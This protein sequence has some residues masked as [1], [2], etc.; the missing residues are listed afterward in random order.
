MADPKD[1]IYE[2]DPHTRAK[3]AILREYMKRWL[4][5]LSRQAKNVGSGQRLL[6]VDGFAGAGEYSNNAPGSP[7]V[8]IDA[9]AQHCHDFNVPIVFVLVEK[10]K[11]RCDHLKKLI[12]TKKQ[13]ILGSKHLVVEPIEGDCETE[14]LRIIGKHKEQGKKLGPA[15]FFLDQFGYSSVSIDLVKQILSE[16]VC[17]VF[18]YLN[19][20]L[21]HPFMTDQTKWAGISKAFGGDEWKSV[22]ELNGQAK[23]ERFK[24]VYVTALRDRGGAKYAFPFAMR[25]KDDR[26]IYWL[27]FC[28]NNIRGLE[29]MKKSMWTVDRSG[30]FEFSD[31]HATQVGHLFTVDDEWLANHLFAEH[32]NKTMT[33]GEVREYVLTKTPC[34]SFRDALALLERTERLEPVNPPA[35]RRRGSFPDEDMKVR[36]VNKAKPKPKTLF[37]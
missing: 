34:H 24:D 16:E 29:E 36:F 2:A 21:L 6:Y 25:D 17:E 20:N 13:A 35:G 30:G 1:T 5:I 19:W 4:P 27:F 12:A 26:V 18:T 8:A 9:A 28:T 7:L 3:H 11:D 10:R 23:E 31:K 32:E 37:G 22:L 33:V 14:L 15:F